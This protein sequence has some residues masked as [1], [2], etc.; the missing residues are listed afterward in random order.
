MEEKRSLSG[1]VALAALALTTTN[2][3]PDRDAEVRLRQD[4]AKGWE[5]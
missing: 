2:G 3:S 1:L 4:A 5:E